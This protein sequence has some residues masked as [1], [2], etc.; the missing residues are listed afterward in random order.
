M[1]LLVVLGDRSVRTSG[2][3]LAAGW[4]VVDWCVRVK[5]FL[6][7]ILKKYCSSVDL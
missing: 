1:I 6:E 7:K 2:K 4:L 3:K 5:S